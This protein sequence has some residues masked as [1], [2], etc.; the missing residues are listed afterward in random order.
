MKKALHLGLM[1]VM[2]LTVASRSQARPQAV[3]DRPAS[4]VEDGTLRDIQGTVKAEGNKLKFVTDQDGAT[5]NVINPEVLKGRVGQHVELN[6][7]LYPSK[8]SIHVHTV[9]KLKN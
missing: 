2:A 1:L 6:V 9:K 7:H 4:Q 3:S 5:W 8:G